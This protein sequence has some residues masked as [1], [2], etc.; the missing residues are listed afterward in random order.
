[1]T[2]TKRPV[3]SSARGLR[4]RAIVAF[5]AALVISLAALGTALSFPARGGVA[6]NY[7]AIHSSSGQQVRLASPAPA[8]I[9]SPEALRT[10]GAGPNPSHAGLSSR[11][12]T[13]HQTRS[14]FAE[15]LS[16]DNQDIGFTG[17]VKDVESGLYY[18][19][20]RYYDPRI[21]RFITQ[22]PEEGSPMQ[23][24]SLHRYLY[25]YANPTTHT[26]P[27]GRAP[28]DSLQATLL[29]ARALARTPE[30][31]A[32]VDRM[33]AKHDAY[34][35]SLASPVAV[36]FSNSV[37]SNGKAFGQLV[38]DAAYTIPEQVLPD[39]ANLN[40]RVRLGAFFT[41]VGKFVEDPIGTVDRN[42]RAGL[43]EA[44][45]LREH[46]D[47]FG[48]QAK[49]S[50]T[51]TDLLGL[52]LGAEGFAKG[53]LRVGSELST[54]LTKI[55]APN[56]IVIVEGA[57]GDVAAKSLNPLPEG[58]EPY[59]LKLFPDEAYNRRVH[60][61]DTPTP[62][63][64]ASVPAGMEFDHDPVLVRHYYDGPG[65]GSLPGFNLTEAERKASAADPN[66]GKAATPAEQRRQG[67]EAARY[68]KEQKR[69]YGLSQ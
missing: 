63:Q 35:A 46:G 18:A 60:Y 12:P 61:G 44:S 6:Q 32:T 49:A 39:S 17:Y 26:D 11:A 29:Q 25:A 30:E 23:P 40:S 67:A 65:D 34:L 56:A 59:Q 62:E 55:G 38:G 2:G 4:T 24:P 9:A 21:G 27:S 47:E 5:L 52:A 1:M 43:D 69:K 28:G 37:V 31:R 22:D 20:A 45:T 48:A 54:K 8:P 16:T 64:R 19:K 51:N 68:S 33:V 58:V 36:G 41:G 42:Y 7:P 13:F 10:S 66:S 3:R 50:E 53:A 57:S 15:L 14:A